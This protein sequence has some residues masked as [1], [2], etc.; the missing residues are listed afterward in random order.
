MTREDTTMYDHKEYVTID[1]FAKRVGAG[2][3]TIM[4]RLSEGKL[5]SRTFDGRRTVYLEWESAKKMWDLL[6]HDTQRI[7]AGKRSNAKRYG[8]PMP[9][10]PKK[11]QVYAPSVP[12]LD[13]EMEEMPELIDLSTFDKAKY[14][15]CVIDGE[16][17][18]DK[19]KTR[20]TAETYQQK[21]NKERG[22]LV[23][24]TDIVNWAKRLGTMVNTGLES[25]PQKYT[26]VLIAQ[27][28]AIVS[29]RLEIPDFEFT[30][31]ERTDIRSAL[32]GCGPEIMRSIRLM[33]MEMGE[34]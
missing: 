34:E 4:R 19:L 14:R 17:D 23:E 5:Q 7:N 25:I 31:K 24:R 11:P 30:E 3:R 21:L 15:D 16:F 10:E 18:Y 20:L 8:K 2:R 33:I 28:Q 22:Q 32:K 1:E 12:T 26:S 13:A 27:V 6:P 9:E 29:R